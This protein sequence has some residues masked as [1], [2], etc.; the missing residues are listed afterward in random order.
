MARQPPGPFCP[1]G[2]SAAVSSVSLRLRQHVLPRLPLTAGLLEGSGKPKG[3][4]CPVP[5][6]CPQS[7]ARFSRVPT[8]PSRPQCLQPRNCPLSGPLSSAQRDSHRGMGPQPLGS[9][10]HT[11]GPGA[12][13]G[14]PRGVILR[15]YQRSQSRGG[16]GTDRS[17]RVGLG[18]RRQRAGGPP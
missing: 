7:S 2:F 18:G 17:R 3:M 14:S 11:H 4:P 10:V 12:L 5:P 13:L 8:A 16:G 1:P 6:R 9:R 15:L